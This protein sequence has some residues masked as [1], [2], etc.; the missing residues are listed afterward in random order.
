MAATTIE[1]KTIAQIR[2]LLLNAFREKFNIAFR[3]L[4]KSFINVLCTVLAAV[5]ITN[6]KLTEWLFLQLF[7]DTA[8]WD[9]IEIFGKRIRPLVEMGI[10]M[11]VGEPIIGTQWRG[12]VTVT[13]LH[14]GGALIAGTQLKSDITGKLFITEWGAPLRNPTEEVMI[15]STEI[16][17]SGN[18]DVGDGLTFVNPLGTVAKAAI[19]SEVISYAK[20]NETEQEYRARVSQQFRTPPMGGALS[21]YRIWSNEVPGVWN[22]YPKQDEST[23]TGVLIWVAGDPGIFPHRIPDA[24]LLIKVGNSCT[25]D[26]SGKA[27]R[28][29]VAAIIDP[30]KNETYK[31]IHPISLMFFGVKIYGLTGIDVEDFYEPCKSALDDYFLSREPYIRGLSDD[32]NKTN[33]VS[34]NGI[35]SI[36]NQVAVSLKAEFSDVELIVNAEPA[37]AYTLIIGQLAEMETLKIY[38]EGDCFEDNGP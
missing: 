19:V 26:K 23:P 38:K 16:G 7:P 13:V 1:N 6:Y 30:Q 3:I 20:E 10:K 21:D 28:K 34:R 24:E 2:E 35:L 12:R 31:H 27:K 4:P 32:N 33:I 36:A 37:P 5:F 9:Y 25:Y 14:T 17:A 18:L 11:G 8:Y 22:S 29:P 15:I